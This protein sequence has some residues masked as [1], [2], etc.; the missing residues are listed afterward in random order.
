MSRLLCIGV[1]MSLS[2]VALSAG[3][4]AAPVTA[5]LV[6]KESTYRLDLGGMTA[7]AYT[8]SI[9]DAVKAGK[10]P[11]APPA[12]DLALEL[13]NTSDKE[14]K[15]WISG[16]AVQLNLDLKGPGALSVKPSVFFTQI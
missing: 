8:K 2:A 11:P 1:V 5:T 4:P 13:K 7:D 16:D 6:A 12:V 10:T 14:V 3:E 9:E 15:V